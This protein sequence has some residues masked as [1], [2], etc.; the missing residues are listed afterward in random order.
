M[1]ILL[2]FLAIFL[3]YSVLQFFRD[4]EQRFHTVTW[5]LIV[6]L[7][8]PFVIV[9]IVVLTIILHLVADDSTAAALD[10][11]VSNAILVILLPECAALVVSRIRKYDSAPLISN[12]QSAVLRQ[13]HLLSHFHFTRR[14]ERREDIRRM[15]WLLGVAGL[16]ATGMIALHIV[17]I[18]AKSVQGEIRPDALKNM[19]WRALLVSV[20]VMLA[21]VVYYTVHGYKSPLPTD[22]LSASLPQKAPPSR[23]RGL[24]GRGLSTGDEAEKYWMRKQ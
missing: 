19:P 2:F 10:S 21:Y 16:L 12:H 8:L 13:N 9:R 17:L 14:A 7:W 18:D 11:A 3:I 24:R 15:T 22:P 4:R 23:T 5:S 6:A 20:I 1:A